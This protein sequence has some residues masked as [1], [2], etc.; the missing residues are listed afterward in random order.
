MNAPQKK[1]TPE[2]IFF[3]AVRSDFYTFL[4]Q[5]FSTLRP[6]AP[7][8]D[9]WHIH[10]I[11]HHV[12]QAIRGKMPRLIINLPPRQLKSVID[13]VVLP[14][15]LLGID[16]TAKIICVSYSDALAKHMSLEFKRLVECEWYRRIFTGVRRAKMTE[17]EF[18]TDV[19]GFRFATSVGGTL[20]G[21][22]GDFIIIDDPIKPADA[23]SEKL[24]ESTNEWFRSTL[25]SR[26]DDKEFGVMIVVMQ[27]LHVHDL[28][29]FANAAGDFQVLSFP[30]IA[31]KDE[32]IAIGPG[33]YYNRR[34]GESLHADRESLATLEGI[35]MR[36]G[37]FHFEAQY[38][39][40]PETPQG[41][42][43]KRP[44]FK[45]V[46][47]RPERG[48]N[49]RWY[50]SIDSASSTAETADYSAI[51]VIYANDTGYYVMFAERGHWDYEQLLA[52]ALSY[53][54]RLGRDVTYILEAAS[55]GI[56][57]YLSLVKARLS[58]FS[59]PPKFDKL[60]RAGLALPAIQSGRLHIYDQP[61]H[62][63]W[64]EPYLNEFMTFPHGRFDDQVDSLTQ[65]IPWAERRHN[66]GAN[67]T[68]GIVF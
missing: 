43:F 18:L 17:T 8:M 66:P 16:P 30:A 59:Y 61:G 24:R 5:A 14:A 51:S 35:R 32:R 62:N 52:K 9:N 4:R 27:R 37:T 20:T 46:T 6:G 22:G 48:Y 21:R 53:A 45:I 3:A 42:F 49:G 55:S 15:F 12:E 23:M 7:F 44:W 31:T 57:L 25:L 40:H 1:A 64:V 60:G 26:L 54:Q 56:S 29:G 13:S 65:F 28:T 63:A 11:A 19:G 58:C 50:V 33:R 68:D 36:M 39:Q 41:S 67:Y 47:E 2:E 38:Q 10:A 34:E